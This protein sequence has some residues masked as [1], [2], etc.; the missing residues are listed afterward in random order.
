MKLFDAL[1]P[2]PIEHETDYR[3]AE[4]FKLDWSPKE[5]RKYAWVPEYAEQLYRLHDERFRDLDAKAD[6]IIRYL[7][8]GTGLVAIVV[9]ANPSRAAAPV[10]IALLFSVVCSITAMVIAAVA[11]NPKSSYLPPT[12]EGAIRYEEHYGESS[13][14]EFL[15]QWHLTCVGLRLVCEHKARQVHWATVMFIVTLVF[16]FFSFVVAF[17]TA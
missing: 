10:L 11:R 15:G 7:G 13:K 3:E 8:G 5:E 2:R 4:Q 14:Q 6:A 1:W 12:V 9:L 16:L 17:A